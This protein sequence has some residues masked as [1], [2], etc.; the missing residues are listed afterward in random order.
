MVG[1]WL[2]CIGGASY[3]S[4]IYQGKSGGGGGGFVQKGVSIMA[5]V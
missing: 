2:I 1:V 4:C 3:D 5:F